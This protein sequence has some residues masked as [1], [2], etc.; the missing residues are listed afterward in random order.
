[1]D[2]AWS[3]MP[4]FVLVEESSEALSASD[5]A[6]WSGKRDDVR[7][8]AERAKVESEALVAA[9]GVVVQGV[10]VEDETQVALAGD[11]DPVGALAAH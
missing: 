10:A 5:V 3:F 4:L 7:V 1:M 6:G 8:V 2:L 9:P 11:E